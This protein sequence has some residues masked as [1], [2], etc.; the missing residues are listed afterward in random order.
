M[1]VVE[2]VAASGT[3]REFQEE[4]KRISQIGQERRII[5][6][7]QRQ[8][9][10]GHNHS[11]KGDQY[12][13]DVFQRVVEIILYCISVVIG[14]VEGGLPCHFQKTHAFRPRLSRISGLYHVGVRNTGKRRDSWDDNGTDD[15]DQADDPVEREE[16]IHHA[17]FGDDDQGEG[18]GYRGEGGGDSS[19][20]SAG[21]EAG[22]QL[23]AGEKDRDSGVAQPGGQAVY[24]R[25]SRNPKEGAAHL[26][27]QGAL[28]IPSVRILPEAEADSQ[29]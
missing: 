25:S 29:R 4:L 21:V 22:F 17:H 7:G 27:E 28:R 3:C 8:G 24:S 11:G 6:D 9:A 18:N 10:Y 12:R 14:P 20:F 26:A 15:A 5:R 16:H 1:T 13:Q 2:A 23:L 19:R